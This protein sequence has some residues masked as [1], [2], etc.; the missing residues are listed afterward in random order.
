M[1]TCIIKQPAGIGDI[2]FCQKIAN[3]LIEKGFTVIWPIITQFLW[4]QN[5]IKNVQ[6]IDINSTF[7]Y[8]NEYNNLQISHCELPHDGIVLNLQ[9]ADKYYPTMSV[10]EAKYKCFNLEFS[11]WCDFFNFERNYVKEAELFDNV[12]KLQNK[13]YYIKNYFFNSP[14]IM[15]VCNSALNIKDV[16]LHEVILQ[17]IDGFTLLD[18][19][20]VIENAEKIYTVD[21]SLTLIIEKL[22]TTDQLY[23]FSKH[24]PPNFYHVENLFKK[25]WIYEC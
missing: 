14:P 8:K 10:M 1:K 15:Q 7:P 9:G 25:V 18:W 6:F 2:F 22:H 5:Y 13:K 24:T 23:M 12:L 20:K 17:H 3:K 11:D 4:L 21:T 16:N 19:C